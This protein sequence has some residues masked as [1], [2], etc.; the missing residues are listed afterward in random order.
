M[1]KAYN[2]IRYSQW[3]K[4]TIVKLEANGFSWRGQA[5][6]DPL[7]LDGE[8]IELKREIERAWDGEMKSSFMVYCRE[9]VA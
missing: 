7:K 3:A 9:G 8:E 6:G 1:M 5:G 4:E 2:A